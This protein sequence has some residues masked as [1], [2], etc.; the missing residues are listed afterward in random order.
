M[1]TEQ[2]IKEL[3]YAI[4][5]EVGRPESKDL[6]YYFRAKQI[7]EERQTSSLIE[8]K[9]SPISKFHSDHKHPNWYH[10]RL[11]MCQQDNINTEDILT[12]RMLTASASEPGL[13]RLH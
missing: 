1:V 10:H 4:W 7:L 12:A 2:Q 13:R 9:P 8:L 5:E 6:E 3:A 11:P